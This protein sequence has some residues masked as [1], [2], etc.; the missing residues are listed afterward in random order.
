MISWLQALRIFLQGP[1][2]RLLECSLCCLHFWLLPAALQVSRVSKG[3][4][5]A[6]LRLQQ[7]V[8]CISGTPGALSTEDDLG[9][10]GM[11]GGLP[12]APSLSL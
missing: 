7:P 9:P 8:S 11:G 4:E 12:D 1:E 6:H 2:D 10:A 3:F 5:L